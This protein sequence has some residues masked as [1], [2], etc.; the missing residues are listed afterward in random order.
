[1]PLG[2][3]AALCRG[4]ARGG[5]ASVSWLAGLDDLIAQSPTAQAVAMVTPIDPQQ[6]AR[7]QLV[8]IAGLPLG[9][10]VLGAIY[11]LLRR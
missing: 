9:V 6:L 8:L 7:L 1:M 3:G 4:S 2:R 10:L 11:L 5:E